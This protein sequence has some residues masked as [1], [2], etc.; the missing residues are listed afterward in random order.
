[1]AATRTVKRKPKTRPVKPAKATRKARGPAP[2]RGHYDRSLSAKER[3]AQQRAQLVEAAGAVFAELGYAHGTVEDI[4]HRAGMSRRTFYE[5]FKDL[6]DALHEVHDTLASQAFGF[7][8][9]ALGAIEDPLEQ[10]RE[11]TATFFGLVGSNGPLARVIFREVRLAGPAFEARWEVETLRYVSLM[12]RALTAAHARGLVAR[13]PDETVIFALIAG[14][15]AV[16]IRHVNA[17]TEAQLP[18]I[19]PRIAE[20]IIGAFR[21]A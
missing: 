9:L 16:A 4:V 18:D 13:P 10:I 11:G 12:H 15:E 7:L 6:G 3:R 8:E 14:A 21:Q 2:G 5:H 1:V 19:A 17:G 20:L